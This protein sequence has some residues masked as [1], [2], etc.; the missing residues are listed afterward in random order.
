MIGEPKIEFREEKRYMGIRTVT[1]FN[2]MFAVIN[3]LLKE[4]RRW[5]KQHGIADE[6][7]FFLRYHVIDMKGLMDIE[8]GFIVPSQLPDDE[9]VKS[10]VLPAGRYASLIYTGSDLAAIR[11]LMKWAEDKGIT[12]ERWDTPAGE[13]FGC[14]YEAYLT[15]YRLEPRKKQ[16]EIDLAIKIAGD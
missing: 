10:G 6:G 5:V 12:W 9:R 13:V 7:P 3:T 2:G 15:D 4:L 11:F 16:W 14:R 8:I 1:S